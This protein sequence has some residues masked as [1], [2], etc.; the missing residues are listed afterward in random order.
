MLEG[1]NVL[2]IYC[3]TNCTMYVMDLGVDNLQK[4]FSTCLCHFWVKLNT[5]QR[6]AR[7]LRL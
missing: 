5:L 2:M 1:S 3:Y 4:C 6:L 7:L